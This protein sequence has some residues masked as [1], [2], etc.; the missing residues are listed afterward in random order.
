MKISLEIS[1]KRIADLLCG[2]FD[3]ASNA[4]GYWCRIKEY[5]TP[6]HYDNFRTDEV[7]IYRYM[8]FPLNVGGAILL[9]DIEADSGDESYGKVLKLDLESIERGMSIMLE[10]YPKHFADFMSEND[11]NDTADVFVQ[12]ALLGDVIYG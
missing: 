7:Q 5:K 10:K 6:M 4:V 12:C 3:P 2:A 1:P 11:D 8:D 9:T